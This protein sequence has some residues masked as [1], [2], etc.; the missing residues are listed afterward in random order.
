MWTPKMSGISRTSRS[1][2]DHLVDNFQFRF[3][4]KMS[5]SDEDANVD[6]VQ[7][8]GTSLAG[9]PNNAPVAVDD[10]DTTL[11]DTGITVNV[12]AN[13]S[14]PDG[15]TIQVGSVTDGANGTVVDNGDGTVTYTPDANFNGTDSFTY[16]AYDGA[17][18]SDPATVTI[19]VKPVNDAPVAVN[20]AA[21]TP[22]DTPVII[23]SVGQRHG[24]GR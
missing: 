5:K 14:D 2:A 3:R 6:N 11:E 7:L 16:R 18:Y 10:A 22:Q 17:D 13:D 15:D 23:S 24:R 20:D 8:V 19:T 1:P 21:T 12:L 4:A 9:E